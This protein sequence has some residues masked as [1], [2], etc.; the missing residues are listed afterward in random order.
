MPPPFLKIT[1]KSTSLALLFIFSVQIASASD[2]DEEAT[3][4]VGRLQMA[5]GRVHQLHL[6]ENINT[7]GQV[8][9]LASHF[10]LVSPEP[11]HLLHAKYKRRKKIYKKGCEHQKHEKDTGRCNK[12]LERMMGES[13]ENQNALWTEYTNTLPQRVRLPNEQEI[14]QFLAKPRTINQR[15]CRQLHVAAWK[16]IADGKRVP[17]EIRGLWDD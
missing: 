12:V 17:L 16:A 7:R 11:Y 15:K 14:V 1:L 13:A 3:G 2:T 4:G 6:I 8:A 5:Q 9:W 10:H